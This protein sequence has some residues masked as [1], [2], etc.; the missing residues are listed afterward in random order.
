MAVYVRTADGD[1][2][3]LDTKKAVLLF[4]GREID[5]TGATLDFYDFKWVTTP[6]HVGEQVEGAPPNAVVIR[7]EEQFSGVAVELPFSN[8]SAEAVAF[9]VGVAAANGDK[10]VRRLLNRAL[11]AAKKILNA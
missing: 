10:K 2:F 5:L 11:P 1:R 8:D 9:G 6:G 3:L 7:A 4:E